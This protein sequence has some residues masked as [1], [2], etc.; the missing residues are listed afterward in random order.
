[1]KKILTALIL[2]LFSL[3]CPAAGPEYSFRHLTSGDGLSSNTVRALLQDHR[4]IIWIGTSEGL[5]SFDG[6]EVIHHELSENGPNYVNCLLEDSSH[7]L[8]AGTDDAL[9]RYVNG[10]MEQV[11]DAPKAA[12][13]CMAEDSD[14]ALWLGT[15]DNGLYRYHNGVFTAF[16]PGQIIEAL[17]FTEQGRL[18]VA[19]LSAPDGLFLFNDALEQFTDPSFSYYGCTPARVCAMEE[20]GAGNLWLGTWDKGIY[21]MDPTTRS[22]RCVVPAQ[23]GLTRIH[24]LLQESSRNL[25]AGSDEGLFQVDPYTGEHTLYTNDRN[26]LRS[27]SNKFVYPLLKDHE[28]GLWIGTFYGGVNYVSPGN[29]QFLS[30]SLSDLT[31][32]EED[33]AVSSFC[34]DPDGSIWMGSDNGGLF[35]YYPES[36]KAEQWAPSAA[37]ASRFAS[38]NIHALY[39]QGDWLW[40]GNYPS[41][42]LRVNL[43][44]KA[45]QEYAPLSVYAFYLAEDDSLWAGS[46]SGIWQY[47]PSEDLFI[48]EKTVNEVVWTI[49]GAPDGTLWFGTSG[50]GIFVR[51]PAGD[52][53]ELNSQN[54][55]LPN[56]YVNH[57]LFS[58]ETLVASTRRGIAVFA[59]DNPHVLLPK[60]DV[61]FLSYNSSHLWMSSTKALMRLGPQEAP[62]LERFQKFDG[63]FTEQYMPGAGLISRD[64]H[65]YLGAANGFLSFFPGAVHSAPP[66]PNVLFT[67]FYA[68]GHG[69]LL[70]VFASHGDE[71]FHLPFRMRNLTIGFAAPSFSVPEKVQYAYRLE[72]GDNEWTELGNQNWVSLN[73]L[74]PRSYRLHVK[75][76]NNNGEWNEGTVLEFDIK[77]HPLL[78]KTA[79]VIYFILG[80]LLVWLALRALTRRVE[81]K[82]KIQIEGEER[83]DRIQMLNTLADQLEA[84]ITGIGLQVKKLKGSAS[85]AELTIIDKN[86]RMLRGIVGNL[87][88]MKQTASEDPSRAAEPEG[89]E[90]FM[91]RLDHLITD[92]LANPDLSVSFLAQE[93]AISRSGLFA[94]VKEYTGE[95]PNN[96]ISQARLNTA[97][98]H[99]SRGKYSV[100]EICYMTGFSSP[101]YFSKVFAAQ[102]GLPPL[103]WAKK[104]AHFMD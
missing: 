101:S 46:T 92:N 97:A 96:L 81:R 70:N 15:I 45:V 64:G 53:E 39:R 8:W 27:L 37:W 29:G 61:R 41:R 31:G 28:N 98:N 88:M 22:V 65:I 60:T 48:Q 40:I 83:D 86:Q 21:R 1:M 4:N 35:R 76:R 32:A 20:D 11:Q 74:P 78:S 42:T 91:A 33:F 14:G 18:W 25:L 75:A 71:P 36:G 54:S 2:I 58:H 87:R 44:T 82:T 24:S 103:E 85:S 19:S 69:K 99:L 43:K 72:G 77:A 62:V 30:L 66:L 90:A 63:V 49:A 94:K 59:K 7:V 68:S 93:M 73:L 100:G 23:T 56:D 16:L 38:L 95:T 6:R 34:E 26:A 50:K 17:R 102:F 10:G 84:P 80:A 57:L 5:D 89:P 12:Y 47:S 3:Q 51:K 13:S 9:Y 67:R 55:I 52:W 79:I 104:H